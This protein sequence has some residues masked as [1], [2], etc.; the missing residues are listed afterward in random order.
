M[1]AACPPATTGLSWVDGI[2][3]F[4]TGNH[5]GHNDKISNVNMLAPDA[6]TRLFQ[7]TT[8]ATKE[9]I[10][11]AICTAETMSGRDDRTIHAL[12]LDLLQE[13]MQRYRPAKRA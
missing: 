9:A 8:E 7:A 1:P 6:M 11:N 4:S 5:I 2:I 3:A 12:L 13:V 10:L